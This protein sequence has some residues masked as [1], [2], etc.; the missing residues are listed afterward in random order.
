[1]HCAYTKTW[2]VTHPG[3][4]GAGYPR[5]GGVLNDRGPSGIGIEEAHPR[6]H[7]HSLRRARHP[8]A[9]G[10]AKYRYSRTHVR[11][12]MINHKPRQ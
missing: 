6:L 9:S 12:C 10:L 5:E 1:M 8:H 2:R 7:G 11:C 3:A 4:A